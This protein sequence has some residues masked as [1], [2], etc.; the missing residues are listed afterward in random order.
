MHSYPWTESF[1]LV[2]NQTY[3]DLHNTVTFNSL[4]V[5]THHES[6]LD[7]SCYFA[8]NSGAAGLEWLVR[9]IF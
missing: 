5:L 2:F 9:F 6:R 8:S 1:P 4:F 3:F 7:T